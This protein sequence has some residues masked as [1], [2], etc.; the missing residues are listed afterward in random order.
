MFP[1]RAVPSRAASCIAAKSDTKRATA[2]T[3]THRLMD[4][5]VSPL[6]GRG[7]WRQIEPLGRAAMPGSP[8]V[9][10]SGCSPK[11]LPGSQPRARGSPHPCPRRVWSVSFFLL[12]S[13]PSGPTWPALWFRFVCLCWLMTFG[14]FSSAYWRFTVFFG[15]TCMQTPHLLFQGATCPFT[16]ES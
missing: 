3:P 13:H 14:I 4:I 15:K 16:V 6:C 10:M 7:E 9:R 8:F 2:R 5:R 1:G 11:W 12:F